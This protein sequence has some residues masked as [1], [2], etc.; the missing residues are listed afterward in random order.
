MYELELLVHDNA[1]TSK[2]T[3]SLKFIIQVIMD[4]LG[5]ENQK[6]SSVYEEEVGYLMILDYINYQNFRTVKFWTH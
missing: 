3:I 2:V 4:S 1:K 5:D 6:Q